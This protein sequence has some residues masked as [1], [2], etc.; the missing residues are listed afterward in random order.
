MK[1]Q[2]ESFPQVLCNLLEREK[3]T[4]NWM[5]NHSWVLKVLY[6]HIPGE[7]GL[8]WGIK[9]VTLKEVR[10]SWVLAF[11]KGERRCTGKAGRRKRSVALPWGWGWGG[12]QSLPALVTC[13]LTMRHPQGP[14]KQGGDHIFYQ[15]H[16]GWSLP[17]RQDAEM[18]A[19]SVPATPPSWAPTRS[20]KCPTYL[21]GQPQGKR[22]DVPCPLL[23]PSLLQ[24]LTFICHTLGRQ[25]Q[26]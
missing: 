6:E 12:R 23:G 2:H 22:W 11:Q 17:I 3:Q 7:F 4:V 26:P 25:G 14:F 5:E 10:C 16:C 1:N 8:V 9:E 19:R 18:Y 24:T 20:V 21:P 15:W 13:E